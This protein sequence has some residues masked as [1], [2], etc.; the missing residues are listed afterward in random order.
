MTMLN[1]KLTSKILQSFCLNYDYIKTLF[2]LKQGCSNTSIPI[3]F[4]TID[5]DLQSI[6]YNQY[7]DYINS[8]S[9]NFKLDQYNSIVLSI[10][11]LL[12]P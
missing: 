4:N 5:L 7:Q 6:Q 1:A 11:V 2:D 3:Q 12:Q 8:I 9:I 10:E